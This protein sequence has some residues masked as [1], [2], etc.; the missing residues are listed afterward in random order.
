MT[1]K[2]KTYKADSTDGKIFSFKQECF[3]IYIGRILI[4]ERGYSYD[5]ACELAEV[6]L[7]RGGA[8]LH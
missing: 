1:D 2:K 4:Y 8:F 3:N 6:R 5:K 7:Q